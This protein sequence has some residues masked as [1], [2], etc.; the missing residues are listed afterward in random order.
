MGETLRALAGAWFIWVLLALLVG[1]V[2]AVWW[3]ERRQRRTPPPWTADELAP[4]FAPDFDALVLVTPWPR[5]EW[6]SAWQLVLSADPGMWPLLLGLV[7]SGTAT[8]MGAAIALTRA[9][10]SPVDR[11]GHPGGR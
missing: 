10:T 8:P 11:L 5:E 9:L 7:R 6:V 3:V 2:T 4:P 1:T